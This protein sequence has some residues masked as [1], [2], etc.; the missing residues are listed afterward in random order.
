MKRN[1]WTALVLAALLFICGVAIGALADHYYTGT[2][3]NAKAGAEDFRQHYISETRQKVKL[4]PA[5]ISWTTP[6]PR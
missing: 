1:Q 6:R 5:Q 2:I 3:V 4:T